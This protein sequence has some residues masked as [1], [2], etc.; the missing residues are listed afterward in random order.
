[1]RSCRRCRNAGKSACDRLVELSLLIDTRGFS[2]LR[3]K[4]AMIANTEAEI[5]GRLIDSEKARL[6]PEAAR[7]LLGLGFQRK[8]RDR[9]NHLAARAR[10]GRLTD[11]EKVELQEYLRAGDLLAL[12]KSK[13]RRSLRRID[14]AKVKEGRTRRGIASR[15]LGRGARTW[16]FDQ[17][18]RVGAS[19]KCLR[20]LPDVSST[21]RHGV[22]N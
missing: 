14:S 10:S 16:T 11:S 6:S 4:H 8:D 1:M 15:H 9:M 18:V 3:I 7:A 20:I 5:W 17:A 21:V 12:I 2:R 19:R 22:S 13:A